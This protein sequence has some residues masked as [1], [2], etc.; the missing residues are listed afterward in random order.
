MPTTK[1]MIIHLPTV[2][3]PYIITNKKVDNL[4]DY[5][6]LV[7]YPHKG[8]HYFQTITSKEWLIHPMF[9]EECPMWRIASLLNKGHTKTIVND[10]GA[11][12]DMDFVANMATIKKGFREGTCPHLMGEVYMI[13]NEKNYNDVCKNVGHTL[14][15]YEFNEDMND[16]EE[17]EEESEKEDDELAEDNKVLLKELEEEENK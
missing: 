7:A 10:C 5:Q 9:A 2:G 4:K 16:E 15:S 8:E 13:V 6:E 12:V 11:C 14:K 1:K 17:S 3:K